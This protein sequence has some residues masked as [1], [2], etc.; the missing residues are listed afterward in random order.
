[1]I[2]LSRRALL[3][4]GATFAALPARANPVLRLGTLQFG[5]VQWVSDV[6]RRHDLDTRHGFA[7]S[8]GV[9]ANTDAGRVSLMAGASDVILSDWPF[10]AVQRA[11]GTKLSFAPFSSATGGIMTAQDAPIHALPDLKRR[12]LG[13]A[14]GPADKSWLLVQA[15]G[16]GQG[17]DLATDAKPVF[18]A[19]PLLGAKLQQGELDAVLT[20]W[21][22]AARLEAAGFRQAVSVADCA[23]ALDI[24]PHISMVG[25]VFREDWA[26][27][28]RQA[29]DGFLA[30]VDDAQR[31]LATSDAEWTAVRPLMDAG[32]EAL[33]ASL[34]DRYIAGVPRADAAEQARGAA[35]LL[36]VLHDTGGAQ[37]TGG[38]DTLPPGVF[39]PVK[40]G[41]S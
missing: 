39:W 15:A 28:N 37:A 3:G 10:V 4:A 35:R 34:R 21:N 11:G 31:L 14:G 1:M 20:F 2:D 19:P 30:A 27:S 18:G 38:I 41:S 24:S 29:I 8:S 7:L 40:D 25:F 17:V 32:N 6:I 22:F 13:V 26:N 16:R 33:F 9:L 5:T 23:R 36:A 12:K